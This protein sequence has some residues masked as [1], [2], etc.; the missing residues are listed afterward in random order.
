MAAW[1]RRGTLVS[2]VEVIALAR[3]E[4]LD[5]PLLLPDAGVPDARAAMAGLP[6]HLTLPRGRDRRVADLH[7]KPHRR[8]LEN[9]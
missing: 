4:D 3:R 5:E 2:E 9:K 1:R 8:S 6:A 7:T